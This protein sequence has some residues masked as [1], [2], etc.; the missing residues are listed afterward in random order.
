MIFLIFILDFQPTKKSKDIFQVITM[1]EIAIFHHLSKYFNISENIQMLQRGT[2]KDFMYDGSFNE[3]I[4]PVLA[5]GQFFAVMPVIG[6][7][8]GSVSKL[9]YSWKSMRTIYSIVVFFLTI[10]YT[11]F[12]VL[13]SLDGDIEFDKIGKDIIL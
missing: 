6:V 9:R 2:R 3:A 13:K 5:M 7:Q 8:L 4:G 1:A 10:I 11:V 12:T